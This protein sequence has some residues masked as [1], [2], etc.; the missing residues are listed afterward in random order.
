MYAANFF[1]YF[2]RVHFF[3]DWISIYTVSIALDQK[4]Q[5]RIDCA[6]FDPN[7]IGKSKMNLV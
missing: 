1:S 5:I 4:E 3:V 6:E 2:Y 7:M